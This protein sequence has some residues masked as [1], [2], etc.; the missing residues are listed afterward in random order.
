[1]KYAVERDSEA[2]GW[3][4]PVLFAVI[5]AMSLVAAYVLSLGPVCGLA[6]R[7]IIDGT[8]PYLVGFYWPIMRASQICPPFGQF[9]I[10]YESFWIR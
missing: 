10:W 7:Q 6:D 5:V 1:M 3:A 2:L 9:I 4:R 8:N